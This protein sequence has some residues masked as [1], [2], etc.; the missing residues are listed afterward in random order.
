MYSI[1]NKKLFFTICL[2]CLTLS[3]CAQEFTFG[4]KAGIN[5]SSI[6]FEDSNYDTK[7]VIGVNI[8]LI[9]NI[10]VNEKFSIQPELLFLTG[11]NKWS[12]DFGNST[13]ISTSANNRAINA[14]NE[15][16]VKTSYISIPVLIQYKITEQFFAEAGPQYNILLSIKQSINNGENED[17]KEYYKSGTFGIGIGLGYDLASLLPGLKAGLRYTADLTKMNDDDVSAQSLKANMFQIG[18]SYIFGK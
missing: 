12:Y 9:G 13:D 6:N 15:G 7:S 18:A 10:G 1:K 8:G 5:I 4:A 14:V 17:I 3:L 16:K 2:L 11:G